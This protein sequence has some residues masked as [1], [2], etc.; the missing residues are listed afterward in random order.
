LPD[1]QNR[2]QRPSDDCRATQLHPVV[3]RVFFLLCVV[4][5]LLIRRRCIK[6]DIITT[7]K[8]AMDEPIAQIPA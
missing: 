7:T 3:R 6:N 2:F 4:F 1:G 5:V 8:E